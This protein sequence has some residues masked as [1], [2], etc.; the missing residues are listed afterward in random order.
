MSPSDPIPAI[1]ENGVLRPL[2][3]LPLRNAQQVQII[4]LADAPHLQADPERV[5][6]FHEM[7]DA[8]LVRQPAQSIREPKPLS[9]VE[10][11]RL[12]TEFDRLLAEIHS[13]SGRCPEAEIAVLVDAAVTAVRASNA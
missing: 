7:V 12:D 13:V 8:W 2:Q 9:P 5:R 6:R 1:Y 10:K 11:E 4:V 3:P